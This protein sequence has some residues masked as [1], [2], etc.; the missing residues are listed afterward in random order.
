MASSEAHMLKIGLREVPLQVKRNKRAKRIY[1]RYNPSEHGF[2][3]TLPQRVR[4]D[5][6]VRF[7]HTK[8]DWIAETLQRMPARKQL[9]FG[10]IVPI[11]GNLCQIERDPTL[12]APFVLL[13]NR[14][15]IR[16]EANKATGEQIEAVLKKII[17]NELRQLASYKASLI[18]K[19]INRVTLRDTRS[20]WG[21][22]SSERN[23]MFSWRLIFAPREVLDYVVSHEV[24]HLRHMNHGVYFW[25]RVEEICPGYLEWK[26]WLRLHGSELYRFVK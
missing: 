6:G 11:L 14:L 23:L 26:D 1:L 10:M 8:S 25:K 18:G 16:P 13:K 5:D 2:S 20:R 4:F 24:A 12:K 22:C 3:L 17:R 19:T 21:S 15:I 9:R 7:L